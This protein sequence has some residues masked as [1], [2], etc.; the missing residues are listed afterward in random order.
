MYKSHPSFKR[1]S[2]TLFILCV[3]ISVIG[4]NL[5][6]N[7]LPGDQPTPDAALN[8]EI[9][10]TTQVA[11]ATPTRTQVQVSSPSFVPS[12]TPTTKP[13][14]TPQPTPTPTP[15]EIPPDIAEQM[16]GI[17]QRTAHWNCSARFTFP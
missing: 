5:T 12:Q 8:D 11:A 10:Q 2:L 17:A 16:D 15:Q 6:A 13:P 14:S 4:C 1:N 7:I 9:N 3:G